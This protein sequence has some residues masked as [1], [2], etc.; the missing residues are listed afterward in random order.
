M[1]HER[2]LRGVQDLIIGEALDDRWDTVV[3]SSRGSEA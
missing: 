1:L 2:A 3:S